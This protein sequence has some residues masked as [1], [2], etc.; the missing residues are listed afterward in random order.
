M[1]NALLEYCERKSL[2]VSQYEKDQEY[3]LSISGS[4]A[5]SAYIRYAV[6]LQYP[7][8]Q[9]VSMED[10]LLVYNLGTSFDL[11]KNTGQPTTTFASILRASLPNLIASE[12]VGVQPMDCSLGAVSTLITQNSKDNK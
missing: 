4:G 12:I 2:T 9:I 1:S 11:I 8:A 10:T 7:H 3:Y 6:I 5:S